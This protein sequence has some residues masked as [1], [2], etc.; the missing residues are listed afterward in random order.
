MNDLEEVKDWDD[1]RYFLKTEKKKKNKR[2][3]FKNMKHKFQSK[4][5]K[6]KETQHERLHTI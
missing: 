1:K 2:K 5:D 3:V 4:I 6:I